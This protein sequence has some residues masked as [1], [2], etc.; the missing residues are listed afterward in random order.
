MDQH[1]RELE[2][3]AVGGDTDAQQRLL[4]QAARTGRI[5]SQ[6]QLSQMVCGW[7]VGNADDPDPRAAAL[8]ILETWKRLLDRLGQDAYRWYKSYYNSDDYDEDDTSDFDYDNFKLELEELTSGFVDPRSVY[9]SLIPL[10]QYLNFYLDAT[11]NHLPLELAATQDPFGGGVDDV[12]ASFVY[13]Q[14][15]VSLKFTISRGVDLYGG[16]IPL[17]QL[18]WCAGTWQPRWGVIDDWD[19]QTD[20]LVDFNYLYT[21]FNVMLPDS[22]Y[23]LPS[24]WE[25]WGAGNPP[26]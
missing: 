12:T 18:E 3:R 26:F 14:L 19:G 13:P 9:A 24:L 15:E 1:S 8:F 17:T 23:Q 22:L 4:R 2:R 7:A 16:F 21:D 10:H 25:E 6:E 5:P 11:I 20:S